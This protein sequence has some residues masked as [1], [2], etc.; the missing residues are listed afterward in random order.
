[1]IKILGIIITILILLASCY[2]ILTKAA[3]LGVKKSNVWA[4][5]YFFAFWVDCFIV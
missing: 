5:S 1:M 2:T 4:E 3:L